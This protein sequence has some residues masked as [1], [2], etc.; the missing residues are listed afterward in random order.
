[1]NSPGSCM[2]LTAG[3][4]GETAT[5]AGCF[6]LALAGLEGGLDAAATVN[7]EPEEI[8]F[9]LMGQRGNDASDGGAL[10][11]SMASGS[12]DFDQRKAVSLSCLCLRASFVKALQ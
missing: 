3:R 4:T 2:S 12:K 7:L 9:D 5:E 1:M 6:L 11:G 10:G 8:L